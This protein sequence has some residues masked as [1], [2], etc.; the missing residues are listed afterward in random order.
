MDKL[1]QNGMILK[2]IGG[3]YYVACGEEVVECKASGRLRLGDA[4]P[5]AGDAVEIER[6]A[7]GDGFIVAIHPRRNA[8]IRPPVANVDQIF[9]VASEAPPVTDPYL[10]D[11]VT[12]IALQQGI[13]PVI[14]LN[15][16]DLVCGRPLAHAYE[17][18][19]FCVLRASALT[20]EGCDALAAL[21]HDKVSCFTGNSGVGKSSLL[22]RVTGQSL[23]VGAISERIGRGKN[24]TRHVELLPLPQGGLVADTPGFSSFEVRQMERIRKDELQ[25]LCPEIEPLFGQCRFTGCAHIKEPDCAVRALVQSG[26]MAQSRYESY[27]K[28]Y[29][30]L[31]QMKDWQ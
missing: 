12:V 27:V 8:L 3:C 1:R 26:G 24:T 5:L 6:G 4:L 28:L 7:K 23:S 22:S 31:R 30:E 17:Q 16:S 14:V 10:I 18:A 11:K 29:E 20:G 15:K 21:M 19:G 9:I 25:Y 13:R 2:G